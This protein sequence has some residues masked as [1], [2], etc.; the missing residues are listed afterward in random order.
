MSKIRLQVFLSRNGICSRREAMS[1]VQAGAVIV[2]GRVI[3][4]PSFPVDPEHDQIRYRGKLIGA[5]AFEYCASAK[6]SA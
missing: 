2:N 6:S 3:S 1:I 5:K 4:E